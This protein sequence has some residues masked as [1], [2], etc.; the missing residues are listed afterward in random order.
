MIRA[1]V[2]IQTPNKKPDVFIMSV[3]SK[4]DLT[5]HEGKKLLAFLPF[6]RIRNNGAIKLIEAILDNN[7]DSKLHDDLEELL[8]IVYNFNR[9]TEHKRR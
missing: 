8:T 9:K 1:L 6:K 5:L 2:V 3:K 4:N 7:E